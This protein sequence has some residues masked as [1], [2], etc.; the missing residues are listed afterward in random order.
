MKRFL[1]FLALLTGILLSAQAQRMLTTGSLFKE[2][3]DLEGLSSIPDPW[4]QMVQYSSYDHR[5]TL[6]GGP[7]WWAN[8]DGFGGEPEPNFEEVISYDPETG[9]GEFVIAD[10]EG[11]GAIV[12]LW[13]AAINGEVKMYIDNMNEPE[14]EGS[15]KTFFSRIYDYFPKPD[16]V[17]KDVF[18][19]AFYQRDACYTP[20]LFTERLRIVWKGNLE[21]LHFYQMQVR[22][23]NDYTMVVPFSPED[24]FQYSD[25]INEVAAVLADPDKEF[26]YSKG[27]KKNSI[28]PSVKKG[29]T[30]EVLVLDGPAVI[31]KL[32]LKVE[33]GN[34]DKALRQ[35]IMHIFFDDFPWAQVQA[36]VG[37]FFGAAPGINP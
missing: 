14:Y 3:I 9:D 15:A 34:L 26:P 22:L 21:N 37:D 27:G 7:E 32:V 33:A 19:K 6:P 25:V 2:M 30:Q 35:T 20:M 29:E 24:I 13:S 28:N 31:E 18:E 12:R 36:P 8:S 4:Y 16:K 23:Y 1:L 5:S 17:N 11:P 10:V